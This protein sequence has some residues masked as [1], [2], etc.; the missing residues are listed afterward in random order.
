MLAVMPSLISLAALLLALVFLLGPPPLPVL[1][2]P[3]CATLVLVTVSL[4]NYEMLLSLQSKVSS[5]RP[6]GF[7]S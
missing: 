1:V 4:D 7:G 2:S 5:R 3:C 6:C